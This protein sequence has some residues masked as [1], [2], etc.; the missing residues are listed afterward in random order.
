MPRRYVLRSR[1]ETAATTRRRMIEAGRRVL[2]AGDVPRLDLVAVARES[3]VARST[4][5]LSFGSRSAFL[6][7]IAEDSLARAGFGRLG[8]Y[9]MLPDATEAMEKSLAQGPLVYASEHAILRRML[10][11]AQ[12]DPDAAKLYQARQKARA[13]SMREL[14][15]RLH[16]QHVLR[17][18]ISVDVAASILFVLTSF[19][20]FDQ[21]Y[22][23]WGLDAKTCGSRFVA[24]AQASLLAS[25]PEIRS[26]E[27]AV[28]G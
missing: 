16:R 26:A 1:A 9:F 8:E 21:L 10:L 19:E 3:G 27:A 11:L 20:A 23:T 5:Y 2:S 15:H 17:P 7:A 13:A 14:A 28:D 22:S 25:S 12:L 6:D 4:I 18:G 24:A